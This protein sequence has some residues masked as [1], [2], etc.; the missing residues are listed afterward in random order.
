[1]DFALFIIVH[2]ENK[3]DSACNF[4]LLIA[5]EGSSFSR[6]LSVLLS[7]NKKRAGFNQPTEMLS[8]L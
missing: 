6:F 5:P 3:T 1:M 7:N 4:V 2:E 8:F